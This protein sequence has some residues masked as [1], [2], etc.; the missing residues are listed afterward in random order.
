[1]SLLLKLPH[2]PHR[3][4]AIFTTI[5]ARLFSFTV[6][7]PNPNPKLFLDEPTSAYYD[8]LIN[9]AARLHEFETVR[10]LLNKR[11]RDCCF[12]TGNTFKFLTNTE[13][14]LS[15]LPAL[16]QT[17]AQLD[18]GFTRRN[19]Y[20]SLIARL[21]K[22]N[23]IKESLQLIDT[24]WHEKFGLTACSF[25]PIL[26]KLTRG[27]KM[28][29]AWHVIN[30]MRATSVPPDL[31]AFNYLLTAYCF[32]GNL[33]EASKVMQKLEEEGLGAD[34]RTYDALVLGACRVGKVEGALVVLRRME[35]DGVPALYSTYAHL[36]NALLRLGYYAQAV[37]FVKICGGRDLKLDI[38]SFG[39]LASKMIRMGRN[40]EAKLVV[41]EMD[42]RGLV[43]GEKLKD[44]YELNVK[45]VNI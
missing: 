13:S 34:S 35:D 40:D 32:S 38:E 14:S 16:S 24:M 36:I 22:L 8:N 37:Q 9:N 39:T 7:N 41:E 5:T 18:P 29:D 10:Q 20:D 33:M 3:P 26:C 30:L 27:K 19:A 11:V 6:Q 42:K 12:N 1:M 45:K 43:M 4:Q 25:Y 2:R 23:R 21:C 28:E 31:T 17:L 15:I 44:Y